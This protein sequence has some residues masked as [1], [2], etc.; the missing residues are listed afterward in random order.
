MANVY[1]Q[2]FD[3]MEDF[4]YFEHI[5]EELPED[6]TAV[7]EIARILEDESQELTQTLCPV[8]SLRAP[9]R[10]D[11]RPRESRDNHVFID[12]VEEYEAG[13]IKTPQHLPRIYNS[14][15]LLPESVFYQ[16]LAKKELWVPYAR[17]PQYFT[18]DPEQDDYRPDG[19]KQKLYLLLD[20]SSSMAIRN[21]INLAKAIVYTFLKQ[22]MKELGYIH[23]RTFDTA[24]GDLYEAKDS[25]GFRA[26][27]NRVM[28]LHTLGNG[29][30][31][32]RAIKQAVNDINECPQLSDTEILIITDG[33][34]AL[35]EAEIR[36]MLGDHI[37][38]N[39]IKIGRSQLYASKSLIRDQ[40]FEDDTMQHRVLDR[41]QKRES[42]LLYQLE[43][44]QS[45]Q[46]KRRYEESLRA[47]RLELERQVNAMTEQIIVGYGHELER[48]SELYLQIDDIDLT[49]LFVCNQNHLDDLRNLFLSV[50]GEVELHCSLDQ[51]RKLVLLLDHLHLLMKTTKDQRMR[52][53]LGELQQRV[54]TC[55]AGCIEARFEQS[56]GT[57]MRNLPAADRQDL[58]YLLSSASTLHVNLWR[59][60]I[61]RFIAKLR[62][63]LGK[64]D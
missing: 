3:I 26:L 49:G 36:E 55:L 27:I 21:R 47:I 6:F 11:S 32:A 8:L 12:D 63:L 18:V 20:T 50:L 35:N 53:G 60:F 45:P 39:A 30:A 19:R 14:Q 54:S 33:A 23:L 24:I 42:E 31:M 22:N 4:G 44:S 17:E 46:L 48:L 37:V 13:L 38:I 7:F 5:Y 1:E 62:T 28:R 29:T 56:G 9:C 15:W 43:H 41:L 16:R 59:S 64:G 10:D 57:L 25:A 40:L 34:C 58:E 61:W 51:M 2:F 52:E